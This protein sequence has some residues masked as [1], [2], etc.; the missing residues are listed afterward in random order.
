MNGELVTDAGRQVP[1][2]RRGGNL[3]VGLLI[4]FQIVA[5]CLGAWPLFGSILVAAGT[6]TRAGSAF[7][8]GWFSWCVGEWA[9]VTSLPGWVYLA[10]FRS[11]WVAYLTRSLPGLFLLFGVVG[12]CVALMIGHL[13]R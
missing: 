7:D 6:S 1:R 13:G 9:V 10:V 4:G 12:S 5:I 8:H 3:A 2:T 11:S